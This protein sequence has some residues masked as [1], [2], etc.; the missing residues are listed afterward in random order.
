MRSFPRGLSLKAH[1]EISEHKPIKMASTPKRVILPLQ[2]N[3]GCAAEPLLKIGESVIEGQ[4]I[5]DSPK[6][7]S[8]PIHASISGKITA[9]EKLP[10]PCGFDVTSIV[11]EAEAQLTPEMRYES[12]W[13]VEELT[14]EQIRKIVREA[15]IVGLGGATFPTHVKIT[16]PPGKKI[17]VLIIN[18]CECEPYITADHRIMLEKP[19]EVVLGARA[20][21]KA[22]GAAKIYFG[23]EDNKKDA[24][25]KIKSA[26]NDHPAAF[27]M[28]VIELKTK[29][30]Q[31]G[32]RQLIKAVL[33]R[34]VPSGGLPLDIGVVV[35]NVGT[36][37]AVAEA[38]K[39]GIPLFKR[40][41][42]VTGSGVKDPQNLLVRLG[43][44]F[45]EVIDQ[46]GGLVADPAKVIMGGPMTGLAVSS[47]DLPVVKA[48]N[49]ILVM[50]KKEAK[51][52]QEYDCF[53]CGRC[54][55]VCPINLMPNFICE[56][57]KLRNWEKAEEYHVA[58]CIECGCCAYVCPRRIYLVQYFKA[59]K[60][61]LSRLAGSRN[62]LNS[63]NKEAG[64]LRKAVC[65]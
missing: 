55:Q 59:A 20:L 28:E 9:I 33:R 35:N 22:A 42:T 17:E 57:I 6:L 11:I 2:Q 7:V 16:P 15:G 53:R 1:K 36:A 37:L 49:C 41:L 18:G 26:I 60:K 32:E 58:D 51:T 5:A 44:P 50:D 40:V 14:P 25:D 13:S 10:N 46:C 45:A 4:K 62:T 29:Y 39:F 54:I 23:I 27:P 31:G 61:E 52:Y 47:L 63:D 38:V 19:A 21:A 43:T 3:L 24:I 12:R 34:E 65:Q 64:Q 8:A 30:P 48:T 56:S